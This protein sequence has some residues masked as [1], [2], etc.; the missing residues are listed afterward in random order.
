[1]PVG[2]GTETTGL[3]G[4]GGDVRDPGGGV[5]AALPHLKADVPG[6]GILKD[7]KH[8]LVC[9]ELPQPANCLLTTRGFWQ[10]ALMP[11]K[12]TERGP[13][14]AVLERAVVHRDCIMQ[15]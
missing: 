14:P 4:I 7:H 12:V 11:P 13:E 5:S 2:G 9:F 3:P 10:V 1:M 6:R 8:S 15:Q